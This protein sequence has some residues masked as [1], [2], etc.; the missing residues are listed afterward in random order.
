MDTQGKA[1]RQDAAEIFEVILNALQNADII[2][3][4]SSAGKDSQAMLDLIAELAKL[5]GTEAK[6]I[7]VHCDL[8]R[9]EWAG[10]RE[11]AEEQAAHY[12]FRFEVVARDEDL[13]DQVVTRWI[14][15]QARAEGLDKAA[16]QM[17]A[18]AS[19]DEA[20]EAADTKVARRIKSKAKAGE[21]DAAAL[22]KLAQD[23]RDNPVWMSSQARYCTADQKTGQV[24]KLMTRLVAE[25]GLDRPV[26]IL[27]CLG[28]R[29]A[30]SDG[31]S[32]LTSLTKDSASNG[33]REVT[34]WLPIFDWTKAEVW[35][36]N[37]QAGTRHHVA[38]D[39][40][41]PR[42]SCIYCPLAGRN[43]LHLAGKHNP[44][45]LREYVEVERRIG[46]T[47]KKDLGLVDIM[48]AIERGEEPGEI[49]TWET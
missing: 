34:R 24:V 3:V 7:V 14:T 39:L 23:D 18:G 2:L 30:E 6:V 32:Q 43:A 33:K 12:G 19:L 21:L 36:R 27:N 42:L 45:L 41:M 10:T 11:L 47:F 17:D 13:L 8:G 28:L 4:N 44:E 16:D 29:G 35:E 26:R 5:T 22:R 31:R 20:I 49:K 9:M 48:E 37:A 15:L 38:Y 46:K 25:M 1:G 40:G